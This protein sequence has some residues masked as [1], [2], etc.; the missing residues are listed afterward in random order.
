MDGVAQAMPNA[1]LVNEHSPLGT[2]VFVR[3]GSEF[4][5]A[6]FSGS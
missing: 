6:R 5:I 3:C 4:A 2:R 1:F